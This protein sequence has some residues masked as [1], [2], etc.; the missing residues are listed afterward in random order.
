MIKIAIDDAAWTS[1]WRHRRVGEKLVWSLGLVVTALT[2]PHL[3]GTIAAG[4]LSVVLILGPARIRPSML[5]HAMIAPLV[6][7][8]VGAISVVLSVGTSAVDPLWQW[9]F[10]AVTDQSIS[11]ALG[12]LVHATCG[13]LAVMVLALTTPMSDLLSWCVDHKVSRPLIEVAS[14]TYRMLFILWSTA[15]SLHDA[16]IRRGASQ[17]CRSVRQAKYRLKTAASLTGTLVLRSW[18]RA[19]RLEAGLVA[20]GAEDSLATTTSI[21]APS[22]AMRLGAGLCLAAIWLGSLAPVLIEKITS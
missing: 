7:I 14:L 8:A 1:P 22:R 10:L 20:R 2:V 19:R 4:V 21:P 18:D 17:T 12:L 15:V 11:M 3:S 9:G 5:F 6:F 13:T 16:Q